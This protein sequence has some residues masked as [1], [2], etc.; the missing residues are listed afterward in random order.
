MNA[1]IEICMRL[2]QALHGAD[3][4]PWFSAM[5]AELAYVPERDRFRWALGCLSVAIARRFSMSRVAKPLTPWV[6]FLE[7]ML[8]FVP[9][10]YAW[11]DTT[12]GASGVVHLNSEVI[13]RYLLEVPVSGGIIALMIAGAC[14]GVIGPIGLALAGRAVFAGAGLTNR[15]AGTIM[16]AAVALFGLASIV[17]RFAAGEGAYAATPDFLILIVVLPIV[18]I[19]HLMW[20]ARGAPANLVAASA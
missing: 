16:I 13:D 20:M 4:Q 8:C 3:A 12:F 18:G 6:L 7:M 15:I 5:T 9:L 10:T 14:V 1:L 19:A 11:L 17:L 2:S